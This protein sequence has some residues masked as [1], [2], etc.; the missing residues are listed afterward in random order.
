MLLEKLQDINETPI[1]QGATAST[2]ARNVH[3][4]GI[5]INTLTQ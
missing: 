4:L 3:Y 1:Q 5:V 2:R